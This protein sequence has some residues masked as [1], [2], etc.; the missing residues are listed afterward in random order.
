MRRKDL[1]PRGTPLWCVYAAVNP[2]AVIRANFCDAYI[3]LAFLI[4]KDM[5][6]QY[7]LPMECC[8]FT[9]EGA[10]AYIRDVLGGGQA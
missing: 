5:R 3:D 1:V 10:R 7:L 6:F 8:F 2:P 4:S 9:E